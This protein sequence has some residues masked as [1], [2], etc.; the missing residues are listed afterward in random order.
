MITKDEVRECLNAIGRMCR[1]IG[2]LE[3]PRY[4]NRKE[5]ADK[6]MEDAR[7][8]YEAF[9]RLDRPTDAEVLDAATK[10]KEVK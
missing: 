4:D 8:V 10:Y 9:S 7:I 6:A 2:Y 3:V 1:A 5:V